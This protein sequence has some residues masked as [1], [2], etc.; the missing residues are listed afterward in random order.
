VKL[1]RE[2]LKELVK[3]CLVEL[4]SEGLGRSLVVTP[5]QSR[6]QPVPSVS[7]SFY[8]KSASARARQA[9]QQKPHQFDPRLDTPVNSLQEVIKRKS[10]GNP[11]MESIFADTAATTL[12]NQVAHGD[13]S[14]TGESSHR[15]AQQEQ[16]NG[17]PEEVFGEETASRWAGL[18]FAEPTDRRSA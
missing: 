10:G 9:P 1:S 6:R 16:F 15:P 3:E 12:V 14:A 17:A 7:E 11:I 8:A 13:S 18:A 2:H 4:L 5:A